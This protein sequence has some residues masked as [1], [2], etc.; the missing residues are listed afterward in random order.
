MNLWKIM[1]VIAVV[2]AALLLASPGC[3]N[4]G[5]GGGRRGAGNFPVVIIE[6]SAGT[7]RAELWPDKA[8]KTVENFLHYVD[9]GFYDGTVFH[10]C[11]RGFMVQGGGFTAD[12]KKKVTIRPPVINEADSGLSNICGTL[13]MARTDE[14][15]SATS[16]FFINTVDN[17]RLDHAGK[18]DRD[19]GYCVFGQVLSGMDVAYAIEEAPTIGN[20]R[21]GRPAKPVVIRSI[22]RVGAPRRKE[23][24]AKP[25]AK[26]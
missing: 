9:S 5:S 13:S 8:P 17:P 21:Q 26:E 3:E 10:R 25:A 15:H 24:A 7:I 23:P 16:Q 1:A 12:G 18:T 22:R 14:P 11:I 2:A 4:G 20:E 6:T 19:W